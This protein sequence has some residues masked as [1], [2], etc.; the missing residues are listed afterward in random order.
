MPGSFK[1]SFL[2][3]IVIMRLGPYFYGVWVS[4][5]RWMFHFLLRVQML[6]SI[7]PPTILWFWP[8]ESTPALL[9]FAHS[10]EKKQKSSGHPQDG[11]EF[12]SVNTFFESSPWGKKKEKPI[13]HNLY[14]PNHTTTIYGQNVALI[15]LHLWLF[16]SI[17]S[18]KINYTTSTAALPW[19][20]GLNI[21]PQD[22]I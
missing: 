21:H 22:G 7:F 16:T 20:D 3:Y 10:A 2:K 12:I 15:W 5:W 19:R 6:K 17:K 9:K 4:V 8:P 14:L 13:R 18:F 1:S 11:W